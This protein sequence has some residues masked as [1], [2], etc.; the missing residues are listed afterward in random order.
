MKFNSEQDH[1]FYKKHN[2]KSVEYP[3]LFMNCLNKIKLIDLPEKWY[4]DIGCLSK[5]NNKIVIGYHQLILIRD[6]F[7][8]T[9]KKQMVLTEGIISI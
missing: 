5:I 9:I 6:I 8:R 7:L 3:K 1:C 4:S 2:N